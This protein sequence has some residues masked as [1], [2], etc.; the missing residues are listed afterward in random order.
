MTRTEEDAIRAHVCGS[1]FGTWISAVALL[2]RV[3]LDAQ[4]IQGGKESSLPPL[5]ELVDVVAEANNKKSQRCPECERPMTKGRFQQMIPVMV[6]KCRP[7]DRIWLD[8]G[9]YNLLR[10]LYVEMILS[11]DPQIVR[12]R[13][14]VGSVGAAWEARKTAVDSV[15]ESL[16]T[17][18]DIADLTISAL[19]RILT[20]A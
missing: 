19:F 13:E 3:R 12:L 16:G 1:C 4:E 9:E 10:R 20:R 11:D 17:G 7:C 14:K 18:S 6:D 2:R 15:G 8:T 5:H